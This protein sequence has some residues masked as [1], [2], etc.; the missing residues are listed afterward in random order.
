MNKLFLTEE[1]LQLEEIRPKNTRLRLTSQ[2][3]GNI[4]DILKNPLERQE[5]AESGKGV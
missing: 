4:Q 5:N 1:V 3:E 2:R